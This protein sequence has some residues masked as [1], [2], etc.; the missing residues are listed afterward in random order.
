MLPPYFLALGIDATVDATIRRS[1]RLSTGTDQP[2]K[3]S[4]LSG[5]RAATFAGQESVLG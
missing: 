4:V 5:A 2:S 3:A 1:T